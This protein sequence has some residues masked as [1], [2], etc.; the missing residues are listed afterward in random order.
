MSGVY[1]WWPRKVLRFASPGLNAKARHWNRHNVF[2][3]WS[4][5]PLFFIVLCG[6]IMSYPWANDLLYRLTGNTPP[7]EQGAGGGG[8]EN[9]RPTQ[10]VEL[11]LDGI[12][13]LWMRA[14]RQER[15]WS[16]INMRLPAS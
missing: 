7:A 16:S 15:D 10:S 1:L 13:A 5:I 4:A 9:R 11:R 3:A 2:G 14:E 12:N 6:V 8:G